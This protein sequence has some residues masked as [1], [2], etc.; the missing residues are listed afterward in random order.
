MT[1]QRNGT[2][3]FSTLKQFEYEHD[4]SDSTIRDNS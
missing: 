2:V 3:F 4:M 1:C